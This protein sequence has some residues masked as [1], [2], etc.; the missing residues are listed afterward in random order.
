MDGQAV[1]DYC[2]ER[3]VDSDIGRTARQRAMLMAIFA[4]MKN[5]GQIKD[6]PAIYSAITGNIYTDLSFEQIC[7]LAAFAMKL[8]TDSIHEY[9]LE[10]G[11]LN[12]DGTSLWGINQYKKR[13]MVY[14]IFGTKI[15]VSESDHVTYLQELAKQKRQAVDAAES[16]AKAA[17][18]Y[19]DSNSAYISSSE[20]SEFKTR[21]KELLD[22]ASVVNIS[23]VEPTIQPIIDATN[24]LKAWMSGTLEPAVKA[25]KE[26]AAKPTATPTTKPT[27]TPTAPPTASPTPTDT[28]T[29]DP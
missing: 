29:E 5:T 4:E 2:R 25:R 21:K 28:P 17:Q 18:S 22:V 27:A 15:K 11:F 19:I 3:H 26:A 13:D 1:L 8:D 24:A 12:I 6:V 9:A 20:L 7:S 14:D 23:D 16:A 10:G